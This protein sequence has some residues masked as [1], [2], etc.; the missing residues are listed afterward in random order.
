MRRLAVTLYSASER[1]PASPAGVPIPV[2]NEFTPTGTAMQDTV[3]AAVIG[4]IV[5]YMI[6]AYWPQLQWL[7]RLLVG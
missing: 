4:A 5:G 2:A 1:N 3:S 6:H 7:L